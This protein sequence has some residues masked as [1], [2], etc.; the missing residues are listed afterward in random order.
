M[1]AEL[2]RCVAVSVWML[3]PISYQSV[4]HHQPVIDRTTALTTLPPLLHS[5]AQQTYGANLYYHGPASTTPPL[6]LHRAHLCS[7]A[8]QLLLEG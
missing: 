6:I 3:P 8:S 7:L 1:E 5:A 4:S 2:K